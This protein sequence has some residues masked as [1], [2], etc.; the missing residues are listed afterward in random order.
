MDQVNLFAN[1][2]PDLYYGDVHTQTVIYEHKY[3]LF[4]TI[5]L[6]NYLNAK[7]FGLNNKLF[8]GSLIL[9][10]LITTLLFYKKYHHLFN[11][12]H[13]L[14]YATILALFIFNPIR[15][16]AILASDFGFFLILYSLVNI[17]LFYYAHQYYFKQTVSR[18]QTILFF[19]TFIIGC[20]IN[21]FD[22]GGYFLPYACAS[23]VLSV[24]NFFTFKN[25][26]SKKRWW[27][28]FTATVFFILFAVI[29]NN[30]VHNKVYGEDSEGFSAGFLKLLIHSPGYVLKFFLISNT[31][32][33]LTIEYYE[34]SAFLK[35]SVPYFGAVALLLY[36]ICIYQYIKTKQREHL[37]FILLILVTLSYYFF[38]LVARCAINYGNVFF[39]ASSRYGATTVFGM[40]GV[41]SSLSLLIFKN[42][43]RN[44]LVKYSSLFGILILIVLG[45]ISFKTQYKVAPYRKISLW[46]MGLA[47]K[48]NANLGILQAH[49]LE[50]AAAARSFMITNN[51]GVFK[52]GKKL[53]SFEVNSSNLTGFDFEGFYP[54]EK[55]NNNSWRWTNGEGDII[56]P[57]LYAVS[58]S[59]N[60]TLKC[61]VPNPDTPRIVIN[62][63][64]KPAVINKTDNGFKYTFGN[65]RPTVLFRLRL[66]SN[67]IV[68]SEKD[69][70]STDSR[71]L[72]IVF[73]GLNIESR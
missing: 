49:S 14:L 18:K 22:N 59:F 33:F 45:A 19:S 4:P 46:N 11:G 53:T 68:P 70:A 71:R 57:N 50:K 73:N 64:I 41:C 44:K 3:Q 67:S 21:S 37:F 17:A 39:G 34:N 20:L 60:L 31:G 7:L 48:K 52:H 35:S 61:Y 30:Y 43:I 8:V 65:P 13:K 62:D 1:K 54:E 12:W 56:L 6:A 23:V 27:Q 29:I 47:F 28:T 5:I 69:S 58:D 26:I 25:E 9:V 51:L 32:N 38:I 42:S 66:L 15:W 10:V 16:E 36:G 40:V 63:N 24:L 2:M 72:G 55:E